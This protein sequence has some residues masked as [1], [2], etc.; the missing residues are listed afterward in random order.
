MGR[1]QEYGLELALGILEYLRQN[2]S[3][4][5]SHYGYCGVGFILV[6]GYIHYTHFDEWLTYRHGKRYEL[7]GEYEGIIRTFTTGSEFVGW[8]SEQ[9]DDSLSGREIDDEW[10]IDN[11]RITRY[12]LQSLL[13]RSHA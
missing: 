11:Q 5:Y 2:G 13:D 12:R 9:T 4:G 1:K 3:I 8:L 6:D 10:Y 7:G